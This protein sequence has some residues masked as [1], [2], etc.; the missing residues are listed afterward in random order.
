M[1]QLGFT[2]R[3]FLCM[4]A[5]VPALAQFDAASVVGNVRDRSE[6]GVAGVTIVL[7]NQDTNIEGKTK[8]DSEGNYTF[9]NVKIGTYT[10]SAESQGF[11]KAV[12]K[13]IIVSVNA[14][15]RVDLTLQVGVVTESVEVEGAANILQT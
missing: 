13:D 1:T 9:F 12:A 10:V 4:L 6:A 2:Q 7:T 3:V 15:Q 14:R 5:A 11:S 8:T